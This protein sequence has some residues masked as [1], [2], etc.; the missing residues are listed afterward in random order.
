MLMVLNTHNGLVYTM[1]IIKTTSAEIN[2]SHTLKGIADKGLEKIAVS[3]VGAT[4]CDTV[5]I[6]AVFVFLAVIDIITRLIACSC[7]LWTK[8][9]GEEFT[10]KHGNLWL[11]ILWI[12]SAHRWRFVNSMALRTGFVSKLLTYML[13][14]IAAKACDAI[15]PVHCMLTLV[16]S[17]LALTEMLSVCENLSECNTSVA[18]EI[19]ALV[20]KRKEQIK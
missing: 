9:Y 6:F 7:H 2:W 17:I 13:L 16:T 3:A 20:R 18:S 14:I 8:T 12:P 5:T 4:I 10:K 15:L 19:K 11:F 1:N